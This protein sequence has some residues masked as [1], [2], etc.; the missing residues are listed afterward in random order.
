MRALE[1]IAHLAD[2]PVEI[3]VQL[4]HRLLTLR[5]I[6]K[7]AVGSSVRLNRAAGENVDLYLGDVLAGY[8][9]IVVVE[10]SV[11]VRIT[12]FVE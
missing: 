8:G 4:D 6:L 10:N 11:G 12:D 7:L 9:E 2:I 5:Q 3:E 1:E